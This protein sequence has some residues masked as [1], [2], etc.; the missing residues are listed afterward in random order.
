[1]CSNKATGKR[2]ME[3][4]GDSIAISC[5][6]RDNGNFRRL[7]RLLFRA[8]E[9]PNWVVLIYERQQRFR[10]EVARRMI[11]DLA[12]ACESFGRVFRAR[13]TATARTKHRRHNH[14]SRTGSCEM[15]IGSREHWPCASPHYLA[16]LWLTLIVAILPD[17]VGD[18]YTAVKQ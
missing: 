15:G 14:Q 1:M 5:F 12:N 18:I 3:Y 8:V 11:R 10:P 17:G 6:A 4:V 13:S 9:V 16:L 7:D 2:Y